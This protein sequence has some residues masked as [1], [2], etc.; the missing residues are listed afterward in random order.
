MVVVV[1]VMM[2]M[3]MVVSHNI[4]TC[5]LRQVADHANIFSFICRLHVYFR[6]MDI[7]V[8]SIRPLHVYFRYTYLYFVQAGTTCIVPSIQHPMREGKILHPAHDTGSRIASHKRRRWHVRRLLQLA[9]K[10][11]STTNHV[12]EWRSRVTVFAWPNRPLAR[13]MRSV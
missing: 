3:M 12:A 7:S 6:Y 10:P 2:V 5:T 13:W 1:R 8:T 4:H 11:P 9:S